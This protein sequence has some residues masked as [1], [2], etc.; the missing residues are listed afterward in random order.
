MMNC[1]P[2]NKCVIVTG[3]N[4]FVGKALCRRLKKEGYGVIG[5]VRDREF[6]LPQGVTKAV[7]GDIEHFEGWRSLLEGV[8]AVFHLAARVHVLSET[9]KDPLDS[10]RRINVDG[11]QKLLRACVAN[12]VQK[13]IFV[14]TVKVHGEGRPEAYRE[15]DAYLPSEPYAMSKVEAEREVLTFGDQSDLETVI[16]RPPLIYGPHVKANFLKLIHLAHRRIPLPLGSVDNRRSLVF[17]DNLID[18]L[19][20][21]YS[22]P[23]AAGKAFLVSDGDDISTARLYTAISNALGKKSCVFALPVPLLTL[24]GKLTGRTAILKRLCGNL[25][26]DISK[27]KQVLDWHPPITFDQGIK[28]TVD[29]YLSHASD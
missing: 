6:L 18:F 14:S 2:R 22:N 17:L 9:D 3:A 7:T 16:V 28:K 8:E 29:W 26:V 25:T 10:F 19:F 1:K 15:D 12:G 24:L 11:T 5:T 23:N 21:C 4:G 13:F 27:A 20:H